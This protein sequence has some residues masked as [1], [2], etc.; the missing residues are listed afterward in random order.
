M[1]F[2][3]DTPGRD[4]WLALIQHDQQKAKSQMRSLRMQASVRSVLADPA[5]EISLEAYERA[6]QLLA[7]A[8]ADASKM[9]RVAR[10]TEIGRATL[11][12][13]PERAD[14]IALIQRDPNLARQVYNAWRAKRAM[15][16]L[17][18]PQALLSTI[19]IYE[20]LA[21]QQQS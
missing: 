12:P 13:Y 1:I 18:S 20:D 19:E 10:L 17:Q 6:Q 11:G 14:W 8:M 21:A 2:V 3:P 4:E 7:D 16:G 9:E 5:L 15:L